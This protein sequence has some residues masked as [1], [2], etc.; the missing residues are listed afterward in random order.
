[1]VWTMAAMVVVVAAHGFQPADKA[2]LLST[3][4]VWN[5]DSATA[6]AT[7][8]DT[9][10]WDT[11]LIISAYGDTVAATAVPGRGEARHRDNRSTKKYLCGERGEG[12][13]G[14]RV[15]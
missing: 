12:T 11:N 4:S 2:A 5:S 15:G 9:S 7:Y 13:R 10:V 6:T 8:G 14:D 3:V 1:M